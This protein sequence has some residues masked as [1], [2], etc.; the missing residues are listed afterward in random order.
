[1]SQNNLIKNLISRFNIAEPINID[2]EMINIDNNL[3]F[4]TAGDGKKYVLR[5][6]KRTEVKDS[7]FEYRVI[8]A[9]VEDNFPTPK[10]IKTKEEKNYERDDNGWPVFAFEFINGKQ[11]EY[12]EMTANLAFAGGKLLADFHRSCLQKDA[13]IGT[14][15]KRNIYTEFELFMSLS[16]DKF[17]DVYGYKA[18][19][20]ILNKYK[21]KSEEWIS[22][23]QDKCGVIHSDY[24]PQNLIFTN[25]GP[26][27][28]DLDWAC[29][30][31]W[32]KDVGQ[33]IALWSSSN[34]GISDNQVLIDA[35]LDGYNS[36][37]T[38]KIEKD[39]DLLFWIKFSCLSDACTFFIGY[40]EGRFPDFSLKNINQCHG[41]KRFELF[42][43]LDRL[44]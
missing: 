2:Y 36:V 13:S 24:G 30:G 20:N 21:N 9:L 15:T 27:L 29:Q 11:Y 7:D 38:F 44:L 41:Y 12:K 16:E 14:N 19:V 10:L 39:D 3:Y 26:Y 32:L 1:M 5:K 40:T 4:L 18:L 17:A 8:S 33:M 37:G 25:A 31:P 35:L 23:N 43:K 22:V 34:Q 6:G 28:I 42:E